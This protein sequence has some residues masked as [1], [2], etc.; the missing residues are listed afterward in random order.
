MTDTNDPCPH[1]GCCQS[2]IH[3]YN[4]SIKRRVEQ[5]HAKIIE[6]EIGLTRYNRLVREAFGLPAEGC[7]GCDDSRAVAGNT[8]K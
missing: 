8:T 4:V 7:Q 2:D 5:A 6:Q 3:P 1:L